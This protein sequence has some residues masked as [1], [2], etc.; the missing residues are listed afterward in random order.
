MKSSDPSIWITG[1][2]G[3][4]GH[5]LMQTCPSTFRAAGIL[6]GDLD[7]LDATAVEE[8]FKAEQP[9]GI[10][11]C[12]A[13]S[14]SPVCQQ[15][16]ALAHQT[17]VTLT[18]HLAQLSESIP[19]LFLSSDLVFDGTQ[20]DYRES[21]QPNPLSIYGETKALAEELVLRNPNH[22]VI[23]TS[24]NGG[25][26]PTGDRGFNEEL[27]RVLRNGQTMN[28]FTDEYRSPMAAK[29]T[30]RALWELLA[31]KASGIFHIAGAEKLSRYDIG[32]VLTERWGESHGNILAG[33]LKDYNG[34]PRAPDTSLCCD[35]ASQILSFPLPSFTQW[36]KEHAEEPF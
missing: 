2:G 32:R 10:I 12:A 7:L 21:D 36:L 16:P 9:S 23:R 35:K 31:V 14:K 30:A 27:R 29:V 25:Q 24:L 22:T 13:I 33:R 15:N 5:C 19:F 28:L 1:A 11:H 18:Q 26:S 8:R 6:R 20:G 4:I 17:N 3:L 34:P